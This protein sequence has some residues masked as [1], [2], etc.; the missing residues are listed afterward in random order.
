[1]QMCQNNIMHANIQSIP[2]HSEENMGSDSVGR[3]HEERR[4]EL[5]YKNLTDYTICDCVK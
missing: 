1:M 5:T 4:L 3:K 2:S